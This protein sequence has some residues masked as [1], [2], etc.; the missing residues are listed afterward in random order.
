[1]GAHRDLDPDRAAVGTGVGY[2]SN[3][4]G[5]RVPAV[6]PQVGLR[7]I[8]AL[9]A[10]LQTLAWLVAL[11]IAA[12]YA[13]VFVVLLARNITQLAWNSDYASAFTIPETLVRTGTGGHTLMASSGQWVS[14]WF[15][16]LTATLPLHRELWGIAPTLL[17]LASAL[18][19]GW[20]VSRVASRPAAVL[21]VLIGAIASP[22]ALIFFMAPFAHNA[23][24][25]CTALLG[26]YVVWLARGRPRRWPATLAIA[27]AADVVAGA[28]LASDFLV[29][30]TAVIPLTLTA[31]LA[32]LQRERRCRSIALC[33]LATVAVA[34]PTA[35]LT[36][37]IMGSLGFKTI[38]LPAEL[39]P[40][41]Q[42]P[43]R[44]LWLF[45][46]LQSLFNG[47]LGYDGDG[48]LHVAL[49]LASDVV[50]CAALAALLVL[51]TITIA[52]LLAG[53]LRKRGTQDE[54]ELARSLH[55]TYWV[56]SAL[57]ACGAFWLTG[58]TGGGTNL[59]E[60]YYANVIFSVGAVIPLLLGTASQTH[61][62][63]PA[64]AAVFFAASLV[65]LTGN[66][67]N[68]SPWIARE[69]ANVV[70]AAQA[71]HVSLGYGGYGTSSLTWNT[72]GRVV[73]R[74]LM[75]CENPDGANI[76][77]FYVVSVPS[78]YIPSRRRSFLLVDSEELWVSSLPS[79]LGRPIASYDFG[80]MHMYVYPYDIASRL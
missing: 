32:G 68:V 73:V 44:A 21:A 59:H 52:K 78:W 31:V 38:A 7:R 47:Y 53:V 10:D 64:G 4:P 13:I 41:A 65:G 62:L 20:S 9:P 24:Y 67:L 49:G 80:A 14:L 22:L 23:V 71:N 39:A 77:A 27:L 6:A 33:A 55:I 17:F 51:G 2:V 58:E 46:G 1:M 3:P 48:A 56:S 30:I 74:P 36:S 35:K 75:A 37:T 61:W 70:R 29:A 40:L 69:Q 72:D 15:G 60:S 18:A 26:G 5:G 16:L 76:C 34:I 45:K 57:C 42:L 50:M 79:G 12:A 28:C 8:A 66:H 54:T 11:T 43:G 63:I 19:V 25:P